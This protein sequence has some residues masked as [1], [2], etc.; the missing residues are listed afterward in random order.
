MAGKSGCNKTL[1]Q[2]ALLLLF[3]K[4]IAI[5]CGDINC[6]NICIIVSFGE[7]LQKYFFWKHNF[8]QQS[9][10]WFPSVW[11]FGTDYK[12]KIL[13][14][15]QQFSLKFFLFVWQNLATTCHSMFLSTNL[16]IALL[17]GYSKFISPNNWHVF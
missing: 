10:A 1:E 15:R 4:H 13:T 6:S 14:Q 7:Y 5:V 11:I 8:S 16:Q 17:T 2:V 9:V 12:R 3:P